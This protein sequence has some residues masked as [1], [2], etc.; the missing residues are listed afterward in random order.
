MNTKCVEC[1]NKVGLFG[2]KCKCTDVSGVQLV[3]CSMCR[4]P[5]H[6]P[7]DLGHECSFDYRKLSR[8]LIEKNNPKLQSVKVEII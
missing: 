2:F 5:K 1:K 3:F 6:R 7:D 8:D 4:I